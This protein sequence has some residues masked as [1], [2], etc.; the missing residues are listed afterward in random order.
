MRLNLYRISEIQAERLHA[1]VET[2]DWDL[3]EVQQSYRLCRKQ[4]Q[5]LKVK[6]KASSNCFE[7]SYLKEEFDTEGVVKPRK[8]EDMFSAI[9][10][11][12]CLMLTENGSV[13]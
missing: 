11:E 12:R 10:D 7:V 3:V 8:P 9:P 1:R 6:H 13:R 4:Y 5:T 2:E